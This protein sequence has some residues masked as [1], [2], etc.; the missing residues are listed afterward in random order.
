MEKTVVVCDVCGEPAT[1]T[2]AIRVK[3]RSL[4]KDLCATH[5]AEIM[6]GARPA[7]RGRPR[8]AGTTASSGSAKKATNGRRRGRPRKT[9]TAA[10]ADG[11]AAPR[12]RGRPRKAATAA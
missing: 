12:R 2:V 11:T 4:Q 1:D 10:A 8:T 7:R 6:Q 9:T 5:L 3:G